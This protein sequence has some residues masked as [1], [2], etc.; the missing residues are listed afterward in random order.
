MAATHPSTLPVSG[1]CL[2]LK[3]EAEDEL[4]GSDE[5]EGGGES[6]RCRARLSQDSA[7]CP[8]APQGRAYRGGHLGTFP[9]LVSW[10]LRGIRSLPHRLL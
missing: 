10:S 1:G 9:S 6:W 4:G 2:A 7:T 5:R 8:S 3:R